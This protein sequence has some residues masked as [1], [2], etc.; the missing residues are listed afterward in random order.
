MEKLI[1]VVTPDGQVVHVPPGSSVYVDGAQLCDPTPVELPLGF[2][3]P[4]S[5]ESMMIRMIRQV[6][7]GQADIGEE[8]L[9]DANDF[10]VDEEDVLEDTYTDSELSAIMAAPEMREQ[11]LK[12]KDRGRT[13]SDT[14][15]RESEEEVDDGDRGTQSRPGRDRDRLGREEGDRNRPGGRDQ[16]VARGRA[17]RSGDAEEDS[18]APRKGG[19]R[20]ES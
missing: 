6:S 12:E 16:G 19:R 11:V 5:L 17:D 14:R 8:S 4:E 3:H 9:D 1:K 15:T 13:E 18:E 10:D 2:E 7:R 20:K